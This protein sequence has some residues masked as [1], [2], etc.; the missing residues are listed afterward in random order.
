[1][2]LYVRN[3][4]TCRRLKAVRHAPYGVL[5]PLPFPYRPWEDLSVD[6]VSGLPE[7]EGFDTVM[8]VGDRLTT[9]KH[10][11]PC[12]ETANSRDVALMFLD[13]VWELHGIPKTIV[14]DQGL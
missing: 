9:I 2:K 7:S 8:V 13:Q 10:L 4:A 3:C 11:I 6:F 1:M 5:K 14:S 12:D